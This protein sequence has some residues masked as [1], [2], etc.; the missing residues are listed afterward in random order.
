MRR[1]VLVSLVLLL[2]LFQLPADARDPR[3]PASSGAAPEAP[4]PARADAALRAGGPLFIENVGQ[5]PEGVRFQM[6]GGPGTVWLAEDAIW[7]SVAERPAAD[8]GPAGGE[9]RRDPRAEMESAQAPRKAVHLKLSFVGANPHPRL[10]PLARSETRVSYFIGADAGAWHADVPVWTGV[11]YADLYPGIDLVVGRSEGGMR[12]LPWRLV[13]REGADPAAVRL[14][15]EGA[16]GVALPAAAAGGEGYL[17]LTT[18]IGELPLPLLA[19]E[20][21]GPERLAQPAAA[22]EPEALNPAPGVFEVVSPAVQ[23]A[24]AGTAAAPVAPAD[25][26]SDLLYATFLGGE[27]IDGGAAIAMDGAGCAYVAGYTYSADLPAGPG[28]DT[29]YN[30]GYSDAFV[31]KLNAAGTGL[32]YATFLGGTAWDSGSAI[33]VDGAGCAYVAGATGSA[34]FP[35][36]PGYDT[37]YNGASDAFVAKLNAAGTDLLYSTFLGGSSGDVGSA[38]AVDGAGCT[39]VAGHTQSVDFPTGPGYDASF[40]GPYSTAFVAKVNAAGTS[41]V[42]STF[43]GGSG[44]DYGVAIAV[45]GAGCAYVTGNTG[46]LD[47]PAGPG[48]DASYNGGYDD[49]FVAKLNAAGTGLVYATFLGGSGGDHGEGIAVDGAGCA[50]VTGYTTSADFPVGPGYDTSYNG[51]DWGDAFVVKLSATG[52]GL[53]YSTFLGGSSDDE[54]SAIAVDGAGCAYVAGATGSAGFPAGPGYDTAYNGGQDAFVA[55]LSPAGTGLVYSTFLGGSSAEYA[56]GIAVD[57]AGCAYVTGGSGSAAFPVGPGY[58]TTYNGGDYDA[59][60]A[61]LTMGGRAISGRVTDRSGN[62]VAGVTV[63]AGV[64]GSAVTG[65]DGRY[66]ICPPYAGTYTLTPSKSGYAFS[67]ASIAGVWVSGPVSGKDFIALDQAAPPRFL[68]LP[69]EYR[70]YT[71][72]GVAASGNTDYKGLRRVNSW[73]DHHYPTYGTDCSLWGWGLV[74]TDCVA[75]R[76]SSC[77]TGKSCYDGHDGIDF[78]RRENREDEQALQVRAAAGGVVWEAVSSCSANCYSGACAAGCEFGNYVLL[79]HAPEGY[80]TRY[81]HLKEVRVGQGA[82]VS[83]GQ[84]I[85]I[86]GNTGR[87]G[88][89]HLHFG[90]YRDNG[91]GRWDGSSVDRPV[92]PYGFSPG[93]AGASVDPWARESGFVSHYLWLY[94]LNTPGSLAGEQGGSIWDQASGILAQIPGGVFPGTVTLEL[95]PG[96]VAE[97]SAQLRST[98]RSFWLRLLEAILG[99]PELPAS[100]VGALGAEADLSQ[101]LTLTLTYTDTDFLHL[102]LSQARLAYWDE[103]L[104]AW[105]PLPTTVVTATRVVTAQSYAFGAFDLQA[106]LLCPEETQEPDDSYYAAQ[107]VSPGTAVTRLLD[108]PEDEDWFTFPARAGGWYEVGTQ[109]LAAGVD[110]VLELY[111]GDGLTLLATSDNDGGGGASRLEWHAPADSNPFVRV[112]PAPGSAIG[113]GARYELEVSEIGVSGITISGGTAGAVGVS[114]PFTAAVSPVT[115]RLPITYTWEATGQ[116]PVVHS[117]GGLSDTVAFRWSEP[118]AKAIT[119]SVSNAGGTAIATHRIDIA[120][121]AVYLPLCLKG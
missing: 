98:G 15:I 48:Y 41:L 58:D 97:A 34:D 20:G 3:P 14:R 86:M 38:I 36:G 82:S 70:S 46:S 21:A 88:G 67:P 13:A 118:G 74:V 17:R 19:L 71:T 77:P 85:G 81:A 110:T 35:A 27:W 72:F 115:A 52:E 94:D 113:C 33:A 1:Y 50:Y 16:D 57:G 83:A 59:F 102:D 64:G 105:Q 60:V 49:A 120:G 73:F 79:Y 91:N 66:T 10:E 12:P 109:N 93:G 116:A 47:F 30:G 4:L 69:F 65:S 84:V 117:S 103:G 78:A 108:I 40:N 101:P 95:S 2:A 76:V 54:G 32:V 106:P 53:V 29:S 22:D 107:A 61:K 119:V 92:D 63:S 121:A 43:L 44:G 31:A 100:S 37:S 75:T 89:T 26:P 9:K 55:K 39:Y 96:P 104:Q 112:R 51:G 23:A 114:H 11:R 42:Y 62:G 111:D 56:Y 18:A 8:R 68:D 28:Y 99:E 45:D 87:S 80:F 25:S 5:F 7:L 90:V 24:P 6:W